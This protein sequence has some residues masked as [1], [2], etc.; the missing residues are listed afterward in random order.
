[1]SAS[2][3]AARKLV[4]HQKLFAPTATTSSTSSL[5]Q[6]SSFTSPKYVLDA[7]C[8]DSNSTCLAVATESSRLGNI[9]AVA[10]GKHTLL[11]AELC[12]LSKHEKRDIPSN[13]GRGRS[14]NWIDRRLLSPR[15]RTCPPKCFVKHYPLPPPPYKERWPSQTL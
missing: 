5:S 7:L 14:R 11:R 13:N 4:A 2:K 8:P 3:K 9:T 12:Q 1:M 10:G 6:P 15:R